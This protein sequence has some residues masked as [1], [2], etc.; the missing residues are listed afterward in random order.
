MR[1]TLTTARTRTDVD[2]DASPD[3]G[4]T[5][6]EIRACMPAT[7]D[8]DL[9]AGLPAR[10]AEALVH[11][12]CAHEELWGSVDLPLARALL[13]EQLEAA[14]AGIVDLG[15]LYGYLSAG[16]DTQMAAARCCA[17][18]KEQLELLGFVAIMPDDVVK[19]TTRPK[20]DAKPRPPAATTAEEQGP[21]VLVVCAPIFAAIAC[22]A[23]LFGLAT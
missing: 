8:L 18:L 20:V 15:P 11:A 10:V 12:L 1:Q 17:L 2:V 5:E 21:G 14:A 3:G 6:A 23:V 4:P 9:E 13:S 16:P 7:G 19:R 22:L